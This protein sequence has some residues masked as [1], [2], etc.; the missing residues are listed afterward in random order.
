MTEEPARSDA[1]ALANRIGI[2]F[3]VICDRES[4]YSAVQSAPDDCK[5]LAMIGLARTRLST[6]G[7]EDRRN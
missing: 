1:E 3:Y 7:T 6:R 2:T 4:E 5:V